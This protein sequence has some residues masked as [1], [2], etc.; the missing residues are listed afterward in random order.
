LSDD[1]VYTVSQLSTLAG[2][3]I[4][5]LHYY[6]QIALL[7]PSRRKD[8]GYR[9]YSYKDMVILQQILIY[10]ELDF[11]IDKIREILTAD[12]YD[13]LKSL[14]DQRSAL[15]E[16]IHQT[17]L[18]INSVEVTM[19]SVRGKLNKEIIFDSIPKEKV[20]RWEEMEQDN[21]GAALTESKLTVLGRLSHDE[22]KRYGE[23]S[24]NFHQKYAKIL[25]LPVE[26]MKVQEYVLEHYN[27]MNSFLYSVH[28]GFKGIGYTGYLQFA[29]QVLH[30][31]VA[32]EIH[33]HYAQGVA[34]HLN[35]AMNYFAEHSLKDNLDEL[36]KFA[37][38]NK[39][40]K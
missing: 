26:S 18:M 36:R 22:A 16:R 30:D 3:S 17:K 32:V 4:R 35:A 23:H 10:R 31:Q 12:N 6:D 40:L 19:S 2:V 27:L 8:N 14:N 38:D 28:N 15:L 9:E 11:S 5:A 21:N 33:E 25:A 39:P 34:K 20:K 13:L 1:R 29:S 37:S 24:E 7:K